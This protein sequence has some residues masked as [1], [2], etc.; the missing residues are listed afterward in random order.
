MTEPE[1]V[2]DLDFTA[3]LAGRREHQNRPLTVKVNDRQLDFHPTLSADALLSL[4]TGADADD[5][6]AQIISRF[7]KD[8]LSDEDYAFVVE[9]GADASSGFDQAAF[10]ALFRQV[11]EITAGRPT[12]Q[13]ST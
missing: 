1:R 13:S 12:P 9:L 2:A 7:Y 8:S 10:Y 6:N 11:T 5:M 3:Y 4:A